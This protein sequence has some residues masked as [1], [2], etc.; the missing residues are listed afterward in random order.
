MSL[1]LLVGWSSPLLVLSLLALSCG[2]VANEPLA[3]MTYNIRYDNPRD[4]ED[5]WE[6]RRE[7]VVNV[8]ND[9][10]VVGLQEVL[11]SQQRYIEQN[12]PDWQWLAV[13]R[14]DGMQRG[15][16]TS[17]G[18][19][20]SQLIGL[21]QGTFWL[22]ENPFHVGKSGWDAALPRIASW[23][24]LVRTGSQKSDMPPPT[25]LLV[26]THFDHRGNQA[27]RESATQLR[28][29]IAKN[30]G[31]SQVLLIGDLNAMLSSPPLDALLAD[32]Q[33]SS[34]ALKDARQH[35]AATDHG[36]DSTWNGFSEITPGRRI[37][38]ILFLGDRLKILDYQ[39]LDPRTDSGR[40]ASDHLPVM[41]KI[42]F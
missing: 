10:D 18:W 26:N 23:V 28:D 29:W 38:H 4:G 31:Q 42:D 37:D 32:D 22:S 33:P 6:H 17:I 8:I 13:G 5:R 21:E 39:T 24:R 40:F 3:V 36:P 41:V 2:V 30:R 19:R 9:H 25:L 12:T 34:P 14:D 7:V 15:E 1:R 27:R 11:A 20:R 35:S 16:M